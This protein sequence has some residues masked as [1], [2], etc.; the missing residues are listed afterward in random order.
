MQIKENSVIDNSIIIKFIQQESGSNKVKELIKSA[1]KITVSLM[2]PQIFTFEFFN[3]AN[4]LV[5]PEQATKLFNYLLESQFSI[6]PLNNFGL[7]QANKI[8]ILSNQIS[9]YD[10]AYHILAFQMNATLITADK[11]YYNLTKK[12][13]RIKLL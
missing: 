10:A 6:I 11:K 5:P 3:I 4:R 7:D 2:A 12:I 1:R 9:F 8:M 13:G